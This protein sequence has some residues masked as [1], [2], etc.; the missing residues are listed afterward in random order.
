MTWILRDILLLLCNTFDTYM[1]T[2]SG[3]EQRQNEVREKVSYRDAARLKS[4]FGTPCYCGLILGVVT[5]Q[6]L[7]LPSFRSSALCRLPHLQVVWSCFRDDATSVI[8]GWYKLML[9]GAIGVIME[10]QKV[11]C[12]DRSETMT[13]KL[14]PK[15]PRQSMRVHGSFASKNDKKI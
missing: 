8:K 11:I 15:Y 9:R 10:G 2:L 3:F 6:Y 7:L 12:R 14:K 13:T 4:I 1:H 5:F